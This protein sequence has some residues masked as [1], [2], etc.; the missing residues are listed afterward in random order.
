MFHVCKHVPQRQLLFTPISGDR[1]VLLQESNCVKR[2]LLDSSSLKP[3]CALSFCCLISDCFQG[4]SL[5]FT[6][7]FGFAAVKMRVWSS[8]LMQR[9]HFLD[10]SG[11]SPLNLVSVCSTVPWVRTMNYT[12]EHSLKNT[13]TAICL[14]SCFNSHGLMHPSI[15]FGLLILHHVVPNILCFHIFY[16]MIFQL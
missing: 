11:N 1:K 3:S 5:P 9:F 14:L 4:E 2:C 13:H 15:A 8:L 16:F 12:K 6:L 7:D 10:H